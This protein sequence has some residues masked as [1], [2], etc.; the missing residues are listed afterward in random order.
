MGLH[1]LGTKRYNRLL[2]LNF[3]LCVQVCWL[4]MNGQY[5][6]QRT[7]LLK[8]RSHK[9]ILCALEAEKMSIYVF[10]LLCRKHTP[11]AP[12]LLKWNELTHFIQKSIWMSARA[13]CLLSGHQYSSATVARP[14]RHILIGSWELSAPVSSLEHRWSE[15]DPEPLKPGTH[16]LPLWMHVEMPAQSGALKGYW[17]P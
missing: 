11:P 17:P 10:P 12:M 1:C 3:H 6:K 7:Y 13:R 5:L 15:A 9:K 14:P 2:F 4:T 16:P 8:L